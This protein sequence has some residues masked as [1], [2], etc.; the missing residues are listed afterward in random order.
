MLLYM[1][2]YSKFYFRPA[3]GEQISTEITPEAEERSA[4]CGRVADPKGRAVE[5]AIV[6]LFRAGDGSEPPALLSRFCTDDDG[7]FIFGPIE[8]GVL[9]LIKVYKDNLKIRELEI[10]TE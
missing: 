6:L 8:G 2:T 10:R 5:N 3:K 1:G 7:H 9:Y 4:I